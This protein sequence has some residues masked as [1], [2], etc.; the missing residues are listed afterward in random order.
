M[1]GHGVS[2][3]HKHEKAEFMS[4]WHLTSN[5]KILSHCQRPYL[6]L[7]AIPVREGVLWPGTMTQLRW[8]NCAPGRVGQNHCSP[9]LG[10]GRCLLGP[11]RGTVRGHYIPFCLPPYIFKSL[12]KEKFL[13]NY[14]SDIGSAMFS[15]TPLPLKWSI[16]DTCVTFVF[17]RVCLLAFIQLII[18]AIIFNEKPFVAIYTLVVIAKTKISNWL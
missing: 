11:G 16:P 8:I 14:S 18:I 12:H 6:Q 2:A 3:Q 1:A 10:H 15:S 4:S 5:C 13:K 9:G 17:F 7:L